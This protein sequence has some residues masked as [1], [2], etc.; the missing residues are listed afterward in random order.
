LVA[1]AGM[2]F[3]FIGLLGGAMGYTE[4]TNAMNVTYGYYQGNLTSANQTQNYSMV[5]PQV[6]DGTSLILALAGVSMLLYAGGVY[7]EVGKQAG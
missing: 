7:R 2:M 6:K 1:V 3:L 4:Y 5:N